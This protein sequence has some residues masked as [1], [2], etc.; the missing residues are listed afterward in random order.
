MKNG[1]VTP[2][3]GLAL[4]LVIKVNGYEVSI[5][6]NGHLDEQF[7]VEDPLAWIQ[8]LSGSQF[9]VPQLEVFQTFN[10]GLVGYF[11]YE[12]IRYIEPKFKEH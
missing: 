8:D 5:E 3:L 4:R 9:K 1:G 12:I 2:L 11:G 10:G 7:K 6:K